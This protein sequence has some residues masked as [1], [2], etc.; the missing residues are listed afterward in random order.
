MFKFG[1]GKAAPPSKSSP[2][3]VASVAFVQKKFA[4]YKN[5]KLE[6][7]AVLTSNFNALAKALGGDN[8]KAVKVV[9]IFPEVLSV[10]PKRIQD[11]VN[12]MSSKWGE[13]KATDVILRNPNILSIATTGYGSLTSSLN[14]GDGGDLVA[15]SYVI[16]L[17]RP[18]GPILITALI[19]ALAKAAIFGVDIPQVDQ[20]V[21]RGV[22]TLL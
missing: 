17:T 3:A 20:S 9:E 19:L 5:R 11:N 7:E 8:T 10:D 15:A 14:A 21:A 22:W 6:S 1:G 16:S 13:E 18:V 4:N 2:E 12:L